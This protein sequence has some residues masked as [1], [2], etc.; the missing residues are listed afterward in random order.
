[1][2]LN[3]QELKVGIVVLN[4][5]GAEDTLKCIASLKSLS[6]RNY[7]IWIIDNSSRESGIL[8]NS[9]LDFFYIRNPENL[10]FA[11]G[12]NVGISLALQ[13]GADYI[14]ILNNDTV[15]HPEV[16]LQLVEVAEKDKEIGIVGPKICYLDEPERV[17]FAGASIDLT[18]GDSPHWGQGE[19]DQGQYSNIVEVDRLCGCAMLVKAEVIRNIGMLDP[20]YFLYYEDV[21]WCARAKKAGYKMLCVQY[22]KIWHKESAST[23]A[24]KGSS[25][26]KYYQFRNRLLFLKKHSR[27][28]FQAWFRFLKVILRGV[29]LFI[30]GKKRYEGSRHRLRAFIDFVFRRFGKK[31]IYHEG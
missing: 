8:A 31:K 21:D 18:T 20:D 14:F 17:W 4:Y 30:S 6:Y 9:N 15:V 3:A 13:R 24:N 29:F 5:N 27:N 11:A 26:H 10:G 22:A 16:I 7:E 28:A 25:L 1:M 19:L 2:R 12:N 23:L